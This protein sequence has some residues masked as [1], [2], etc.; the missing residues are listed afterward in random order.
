MCI[1]LLSGTGEG[2]RNLRRIGMM[3]SMT[4]Q[5]WLPPAKILY[6]FF[7]PMFAMWWNEV[8]DSLSFKPLIKY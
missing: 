8:L 3:S 7:A 4:T 5:L 1:C 2:A 6:T